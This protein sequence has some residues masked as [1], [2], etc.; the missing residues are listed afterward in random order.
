[1]R[2]LT[3]ILFALVASVVAMTA[4]PPA[5]QAARDALAALTADDHQQMMAQL[6]IRTLRPA[7][8]GRESAPNQANYDET[9]ANPFP[10]LP[11]PLTLKNGKPVTT[12][13]A[14]WKQR[15]PEIVEDFEREVLGR[16]PRTVPAIK[17]TVTGTE[18]WAAGSHAVVGRQFVGHVDN[19]SAPSIRVDI[20]MTLVVPVDAKQPVPVMIMFGNGLLPSAAAAAARGRAGRPSPAPSAT[21]DPPATEQLIADGWG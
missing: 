20:Q 2:C 6:G 10:N 15:R 16:V 12:A 14:W 21:T 7:P 3:A 8:S 11:D 19:S 9:I 5:D 1:M 18:Q 4:Q 17:W 13:D